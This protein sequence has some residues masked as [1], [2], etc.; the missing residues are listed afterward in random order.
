M[1]VLTYSLISQISRGR[2]CAKAGSQG[3][4]AAFSSLTYR[5]SDREY[6]CEIVQGEGMK[7][8]VSVLAKSGASPFQTVSWGRWM[9]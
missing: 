9:P 8:G 7:N 4:R 2:A 5:S 3:R 1:A 6:V